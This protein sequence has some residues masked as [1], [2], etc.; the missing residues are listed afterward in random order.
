MLRTGERRDLVQVVPPLIGESCAALASMFWGLKSESSVCRAGSRRAGVL[1]SCL[2]KNILE[3]WAVDHI[4][5]Y[6]SLQ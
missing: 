2:T 4:G 3:M 1:E 5:V 6:V